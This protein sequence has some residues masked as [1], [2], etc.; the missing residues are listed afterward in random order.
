[1][2]KAHTMNLSLLLSRW[3]HSVATSSSLASLQKSMP[4]LRQKALVHS[5][6]D[7]DLDR[8]ECGR[9]RAASRGGWA[10]GSGLKTRDRREEELSCSGPSGMMVLF[11]KQVHL[12]NVGAAGVSVLALVS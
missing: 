9:D 8:G 10:A 11:L 7:L 3:K 12:Q 4:W 6:H 5:E 2:M 1:M